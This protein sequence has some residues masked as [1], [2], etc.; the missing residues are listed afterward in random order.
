MVVQTTSVIVSITSMRFWILL[1]GAA[2]VS[3]GRRPAAATRAT[4]EFFIRAIVNE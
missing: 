4:R 2:S 1:S 3:D